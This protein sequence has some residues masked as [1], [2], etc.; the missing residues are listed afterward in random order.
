[1]SVPANRLIVVF[2]KNPEPGKVKTRLGA[3]VGMEEAARIYGLLVE[4]VVSQLCQASGSPLCLYFDPASALARESL[5]SWLMPILQNHEVLWWGQP[6]GDLGDRQAHAVS[7][8]FRNGFAKVL[9]VGT[10]CVDL[11]PEILE[12][13]W[14]SLEDHDWSF[15]PTLDGGYYLA[16]TRSEHGGVF[17]RVRW[18]SEHTLGDCQRNAER[19]GQSVHLLSETLSDIDTED[20]WR[21]VKDRLENGDAKDR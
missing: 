18:S 15:G 14:D 11:T 16:A 21:L 3:S 13:A 9:L 19:A 4:R 5:R 6:S 10:D 1:M 8:A 12:E 2:L 7:E 17:Q 20:D